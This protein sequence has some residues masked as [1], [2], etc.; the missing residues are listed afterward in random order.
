MFLRKSLLPL[1]LL[2]FISIAQAEKPAVFKVEVIIFESL[3][4]KGWTEERWKD[5]I[6][7]IDLENATYVKPLDSNENMLNE[8]AKKM[9]E[10]KGYHKLFHQSWLVEAKEEKYA[11]PILIQTNKGSDLDGSIVFYKSRYP[12]IKLNLELNRRIPS[13]VKEAFALQQ[14]IEIDELPD[15]WQFTI[16]EARKLKSNQ[17]HYIDHPIFG[18]LVQIQWQKGD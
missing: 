15:K 13:R 4:L 7:M 9:T 17:L 16:S 5:D 11:T 6:E 1:F 10:K 3:A 2:S 18:A 12:H 8:Q 14:N